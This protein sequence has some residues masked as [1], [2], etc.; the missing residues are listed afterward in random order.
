MRLDLPRD[1]WA[2][3]RDPDEIPRKAARAFR[4]ELY[5]L[6]GRVGDVDPELDQEEAARA[7]AVALLKSDGALD[8]IED[9]AEVLV[10]AVVAEWSYGEVS[11]DVLDSMPDAAVDAIYDYVQAHAYIEK[12]MPDFSPSQDEDSPTTPSGA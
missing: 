10:L 7:A 4:K 1:N 8:G 2:E 11:A 3:I 9:M 12:L 5:R 6:S